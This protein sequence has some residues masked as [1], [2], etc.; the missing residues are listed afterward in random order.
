MSKGD[1]YRGLCEDWCRLQTMRDI[2]DKI[3][4]PHLNDG[5]GTSTKIYDDLRRSIQI[6]ETALRRNISA[7]ELQ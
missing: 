6:A 2:L 4:P 5:T 1:H 3:Q 7:E